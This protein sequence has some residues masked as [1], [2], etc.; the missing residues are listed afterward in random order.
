MNI[1]LKRQEVKYH[2]KHKNVSQVEIVSGQ[3]PTFKNVCEIQLVK[4]TSH[5]LLIYLG[6]KWSLKNILQHNVFPI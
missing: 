6:T 2:Q 3:I 1:M 5:P 4:F